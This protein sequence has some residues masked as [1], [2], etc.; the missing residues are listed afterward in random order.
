MSNP[1]ISLSSVSFAWPDGSPV[2]SEL[3]L[4]VPAGRCGL[5][6]INGAGKSTLLRLIGGELA[7][8]SGHILVSGQVGYLPQDL[9]PDADLRVAEFLGIAAV[10][11]AIRAVDG[12]AV[13]P[14]YFDVIGDDWDVEHRAL[15]A[16]SRL[17]LPANALR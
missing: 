7:P 4:L 9:T 10:L 12:G 17:G 8:T 15:A 13:D 2:F 6:G 11:E 14:G 3:D 5:V 1:A 16:L